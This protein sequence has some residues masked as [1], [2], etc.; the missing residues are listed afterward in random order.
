MR[1][2]VMTFLLVAALAPPAT[3]Q[4]TEALFNG[5]DLKGWKAE[6]AKARVRD[7]VI[8]RRT[9]A[10]L[11]THRTALWRLDSDIRNQDARRRQGRRVRPR[12]ADLR[13]GFRAG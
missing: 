4:V 2:A 3:A 7:A 12:L 8:P 6:H 13:Q 11:G 1:P 9:V 10:R 5:R